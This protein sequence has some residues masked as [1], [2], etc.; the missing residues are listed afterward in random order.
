M[1]VVAGGGE[2]RRD[3]SG[4]SRA[5]LTSGVGASGHPGGPLMVHHGTANGVVQG[6]SP[7]VAGTMWWV[8]SRLV[9]LGERAD[10]LR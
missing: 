9:P 3:L 5:S 10:E 8:K 1:G 6:V 7:G 2:S 4:E